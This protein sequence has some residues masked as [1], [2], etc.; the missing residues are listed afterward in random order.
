M[1]DQAALSNQV[2]DHTASKK[3]VT[4]AIVDIIAS[5][6]R[7]T[8]MHRSIDKDVLSLLVVVHICI[9]STC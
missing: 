9:L 3:A 1:Y 4:H 6:L 2:I 5:M 8:Y 7:A